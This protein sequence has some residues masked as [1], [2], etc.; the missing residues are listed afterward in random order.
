MYVLDRSSFWLGKCKKKIFKKFC[1]IRGLPTRLPQILEILTF[2]NLLE[3]L[4]E[5]LNIFITKGE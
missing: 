1:K 2:V 3:Q 5:S 4:G